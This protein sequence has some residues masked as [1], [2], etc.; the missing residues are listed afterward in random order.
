MRED[1]PPR[2][3]DY[4]EKVALA[5]GQEVERLL[6]VLREERKS[7]WS[8]P[9]TCCI[10]CA[11]TPLVVWLL[12]VLSSLYF[13]LSSL[14][15]AAAVGMVLAL[16][17]TGWYATTRLSTSAR[18]K[19]SLERLA[20]LNDVRSVPALITALSWSDIRELEPIVHSGLIRLLPK[21]RAADAE[22]LT[23]NHRAILRR[24][25]RNQDSDLVMAILRALEVIGNPDDI[26][27][28]DILAIQSAGTGAELRVAEAARAC[29]RKLEA[30]FLE[31]GHTLLRIPDESAPPLLRPAGGPSSSDSDRLLRPRD[32]ST[33]DDA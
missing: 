17:I 10:G 1:Q 15:L 21:L 32:N 29:L 14:F 25:L 24:N 23:W 19:D 22:M 12:T 11:S 3:W 30:K 7:R 26:H 33:E 16:V 2:I 13:Q 28:V 4:K 27:V 9:K 6:A 5:E 18:Q 8:I 20:E 31:P